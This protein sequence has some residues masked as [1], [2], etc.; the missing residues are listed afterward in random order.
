MIISSDE[1]ALPHHT[2]NAEES[3]PEQQ[4][5]A[6][7]GCSGYFPRAA[8]AGRPIATRRARIEAAGSAERVG[9]RRFVFVE[10]IG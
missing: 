2:E 4:D 10:R 3:G 5:R 8:A 9:W 7:L 1:A 6:W